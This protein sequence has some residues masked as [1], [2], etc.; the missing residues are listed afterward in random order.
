MLVNTEGSAHGGQH[1]AVVLSTQQCPTATWCS[2][3]SRPFCLALEEYQ[4]CDKK[5]STDLIYLSNITENHLVKF[6]TTIHTLLVTSDS[7][8]YNIHLF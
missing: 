5:T 2:H 1:W 6:S 4:I 8:K 3:Q 7:V